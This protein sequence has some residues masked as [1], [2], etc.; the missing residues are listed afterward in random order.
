MMNPIEYENYHDT[1]KGYDNTRI[2]I[3]IEILLG[4]FAST[5]RPLPEQHILDGGCG[6][7]NYIQAL[8][9]KLY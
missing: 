5:P 4:C 6:N 8:K 2:P 3:G 1:S 9:K 7:G